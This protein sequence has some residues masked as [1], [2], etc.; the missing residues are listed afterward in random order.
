MNNCKLV[1]LL[2]CILGSILGAILIIFNVK[3]RTREKYR[4]QDR[5]NT[6]F[7]S[8]ANYRDNDCK[9]ELKRQ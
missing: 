4:R 6:I 8:L 3:S 2:S 9:N 7:I 1:I 5:D